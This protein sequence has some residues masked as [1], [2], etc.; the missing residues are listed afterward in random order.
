[1]RK[2]YILALVLIGLLFAATLTVGTGYGLYLSTSGSKKTNAATID[3]FEV[4]YSNSDTIELKN[5]YIIKTCRGRCPHRPEK[6][7]LQ[8][9]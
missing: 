6:N 7:K 5:I 3:C 2:K 8:I 1:M 9:L 4:Y